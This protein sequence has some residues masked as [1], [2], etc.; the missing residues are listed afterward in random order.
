VL[1]DLLIAPDGTVAALMVDQDGAM[2]E[3]E[4]AGLRIEY[5]STA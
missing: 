5:V 3:V 1:R 2:R 4:P